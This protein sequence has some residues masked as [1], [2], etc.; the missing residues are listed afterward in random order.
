MYRVMAGYRG[1]HE[2]LI[3]AAEQ[4]VADSSAEEAPAAAQ[5]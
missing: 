2:V 4:I 1:G 5:A 3:R